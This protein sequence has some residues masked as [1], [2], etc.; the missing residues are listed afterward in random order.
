M[1]SRNRITSGEERYTGNIPPAYNGNRFSYARREHGGTPTYP[2]KEDTVPVEPE[3]P[4]E[5]S[6]MEETS[7]EEIPEEVALPPQPESRAETPSHGASG[8]FLSGIGQEELL[9]IALLLLLSAEHERSMDIIVILLL[10]IGI[11]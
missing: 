2:E 7:A 1:Y 5:E 9:L 6:S 3:V 8:G 11:H 10:L 4:D